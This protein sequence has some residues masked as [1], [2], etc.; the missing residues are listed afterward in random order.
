MLDYKTKAS[1]RFDQETDRDYTEH[2]MFYRE[3]LGNGYSIV[4]QVKA[5][6]IQAKENSSEYDWVY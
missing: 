2:L 4:E 5:Q 1:Y 6:I 3:G